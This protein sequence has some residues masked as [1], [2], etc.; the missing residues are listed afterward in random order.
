MAC[1]VQGTLL[2]GWLAA[3]GLLRP[4]INSLF[5]G[6][7]KHLYLVTPY[8]NFF[9]AQRISPLPALLAIFAFWHVFTF[10]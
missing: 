2:A 3:V 5:A 7:T 1:F 8:D 6:F 9:E 4:L 10:A